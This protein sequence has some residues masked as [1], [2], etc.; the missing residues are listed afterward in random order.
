MSSEKREDGPC[1]QHKHSQHPQQIHKCRQA[2][3]CTSPNTAALLQSQTHCKDSAR[4]EHPIICVVLN[5][6]DL[7]AWEKKPRRFE[8][9]GRRRRSRCAGVRRKRRLPARRP[10]GRR[11]AEP[12]RARRGAAGAN[13]R[14][15]TCALATPTTTAASPAADHRQRVGRHRGKVQCNALGL[16]VSPTEHLPLCCRRQRPAVHCLQMERDVRV[17]M[18]ALVRRF[19]RCCTK[20]QHMELLVVW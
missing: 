13:P 18:R 3:P 4:A 20:M 15:P 19:C 16:C 2:E 6:W 11:C 7:N 17:T 9:R 14:A 12:T 8:P 10:H 1:P 5:A